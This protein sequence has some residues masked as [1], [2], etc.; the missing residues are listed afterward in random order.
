MI[1]VSYKYTV[2]SIRLSRKIVKI[3]QFFLQKAIHEEQ[4][5]LKTSTL[6]R[7]PMHEIN[8]EKG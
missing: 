5:C 2:N 3:V 6:K 4:L 7:D 1:H 8:Q